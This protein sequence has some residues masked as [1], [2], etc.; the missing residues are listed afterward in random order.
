MLS[1][2]TTVQRPQLNSVNL[3]G[4]HLWDAAA[5]ERVRER[6]KKKNKRR[7]RKEEKQTELEWP[8]SKTKF[9][10]CYT[11]IFCAVFILGV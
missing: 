3:G 1:E 5:Y 10:H 6:E 4:N 11:Y 8:W 7:R 2:E 9:C